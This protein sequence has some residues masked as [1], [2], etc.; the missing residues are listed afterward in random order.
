VS[1]LG[2]REIDMNPQSRPIICLMLAMAALASAACSTTTQRVGPS[3][4][5]MSQHG[6]STG[7][8]VLI[9]YKNEGDALSSSRSE[10]LRIIDIG[11]N[12]ISGISETR[13]GVTVVDYDDIFQLE[14]IRTDV[15]KLDLPEPSE[16]VVEAVKDTGRAV[17]TL[18]GVYLLG[19][20][21]P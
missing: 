10:P 2:A 18:L 17:G 19:M 5:A 12:A 15:A 7:D 11:K 8:T 3:Q 16:R 20:S 9:R 4:A 14:H 6:I 13:Q 21:S 1:N